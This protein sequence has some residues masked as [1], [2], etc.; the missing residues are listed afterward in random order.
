MCAKE[1]G[2]TPGAFRLLEIDDQVEM[3]ATIRARN[4]ISAIEAKE[5]AKEMER[6]SK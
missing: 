4:I 1:Y 3:L 6:K 2:L 5:R